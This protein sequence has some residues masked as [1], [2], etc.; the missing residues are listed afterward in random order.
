MN[1]IIINRYEKVKE[2]ILFCLLAIWMLI[3]FLKEIRIISSFVTKNEYTFIMTAGSIGVIFLLIEIYRSS[4]NKEK[5]QGYDKQMLPIILLCIYMMWTYISTLFSE[6]TS[7]AFNGT[8][9]RKEGYITYI[10]YAG[11]FACAFLIKSKKS[12]KILINMLVIVAML[13]I[14]AVEAYYKSILDNLWIPRLKNKTCFLNRNHYGYYLLLATVSSIFLFITQKNNIIKILYLVSS[15]FLLYF[16]V[17]NNT[18]GC[19]IALI[20]TL[21]FF[22][23]YAIC[24]KKIK[25]NTIVFIIIL[26]VMAL[27][28]QKIR[29][30]IEKNF[31]GLVSNIN[32][33]IIAIN[34]HGDEESIKIAEKA[35]SQRIRLWIKGIEF[36]AERP[37]LGYG[38]DSLGVRYAKVGISNDRP[39]NLLIQLATTSGIVGLIIYV[40]AIGII[41]I[42]GIKNLKLGNRINIIALASVIAYLISAMFGN[43]MYYTSPY[44]FIFLGM[45]MSENMKGIEETNKNGD[46]VKEEK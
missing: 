42:R 8:K 25:I 20:V 27:M 46:I 26:I 2:T 37:I 15:L 10:A 23:I 4:V 1:T 17:L 30:T 22:I 28:N 11:F 43:S 13:N 3:P 34:S 5:K 21:I 31:K 16:L 35:G 44:F 39:H 6:N 41:V 19:F 40:T 7:I 45:L 38:P 9:Y 29:T 36:F 14:I 33:I 18:F 32:D 12:K 24:K